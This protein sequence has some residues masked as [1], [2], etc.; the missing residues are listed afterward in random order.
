MPQ[1][2]PKKERKRRKGR[3][4]GIGVALAVNAE[5]A[6]SQISE[7]FQGKPMYQLAFAK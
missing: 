2:Q 7:G 6:D 1:V 3:K 4:G 5:Q